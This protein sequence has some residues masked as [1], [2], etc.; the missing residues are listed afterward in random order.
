MGYALAETAQNVGANVVL[1]SGPTALKPPSGVRF[2]PVVS[3]RDMLRAALRHGK[4][5][6]LIIGAAAVADWRPTHFQSRKIKKF[7]ASK[8]KIT[9]TRNPDIIKTLSK[10]F[11][12]NPCFVIGFAL[13]T[14][15][16]LANAGKKLKEKSLDMIVANPA[17]VIDRRTTQAYILRPG[18]P[19][20]RFPSLSKASL[21]RHILS[22]A[23]ESLP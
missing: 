10:R 14:N 20:L 7:G 5:A 12:Q 8:M 23:A 18:K 2:V 17:R 6:D 21:A 22:L 11:N 9:L 3:A 1:I 16:L 13:E 19:T 15:G 4:R